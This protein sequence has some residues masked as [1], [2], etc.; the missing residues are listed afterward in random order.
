MR[1]KLPN[2]I[3]ITLRVACFAA[4]MLVA[5]VGACTQT[6]WLTCLGSTMATITT[7]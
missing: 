5:I 4:W 2:D 6:T 1:A 3:R 7:L